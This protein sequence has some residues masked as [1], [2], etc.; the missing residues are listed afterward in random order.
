MPHTPVPS[1]HGY[2]EIPITGAARKPLKAVQVHQDGKAL[3]VDL[4]FEDDSMLE[5][6]FDVSFA[7]SAKLL[8]YKD[9]DYH[10]RRRIRPR[11]SES[12]S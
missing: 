10:L 11:K 5:M 2:I 1:G 6:S 4:E 8:D 3:N 7:A 9:D 12:L